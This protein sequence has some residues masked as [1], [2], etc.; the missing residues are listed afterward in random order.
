[1]DSGETPETNAHSGAVTGVSSDAC[2]QYAVSC[3][4]D[5]YL[6]VWGFKS[7]RLIAEAHVGVR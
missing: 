2:N 6:R 7:R 5:G 4:T 3:S 1:M